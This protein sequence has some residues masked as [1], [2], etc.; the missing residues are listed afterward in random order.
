MNPFTLAWFLLS[1]PVSS[2]TH[3]TYISIY[4]P[5]SHGFCFPPLHHLS[6]TSPISFNFDIMST[7]FERSLIKADMFFMSGACIA[8]AWKRDVCMYS[9]ASS[10]HLPSLLIKLLQLSP[11]TI[12][13]ALRHS[14]KK[15]TIHQV[16]T[17]LATSKNVLFPG[18]NNLLTT[19]ADDPTL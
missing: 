11:Y 4:P 13:F 8:I 5:S 17:M 7:W 2:L 3:I 12:H 9:L 1:T 18:H 19:G 6:P 16:T 10:Y 14:A 15:A